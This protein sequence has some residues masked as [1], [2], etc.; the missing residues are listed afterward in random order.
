[1]LL[2]PSQFFR[3]GNGVLEP[4]LGVDP[5]VDDIALSGELLGQFVLVV[6]EE[7]GVG[8]HDERDGNAQGV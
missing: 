4:V 6:V 1:M 2:A 7:G 5:A 8:D 3:F